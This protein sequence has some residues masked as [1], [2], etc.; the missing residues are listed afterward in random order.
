MTIQT[1]DGDTIEIEREANRVR[2]TTQD[3]SAYEGEVV[4]LSLTRGDINQLIKA[5]TELQQ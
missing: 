4:T 2:I 5:L 1:Y 3:A